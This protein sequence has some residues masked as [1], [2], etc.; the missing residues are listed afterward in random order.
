[1]KTKKILAFLLI[2]VFIVYLLPAGSANAMQIFVQIAVY[3]ALRTV[4]LEVEPGDYVYNIKSKVEDKTGIPTAF[5]QLYY[6]GVLLEDDHT[7]ADYNVQKESY[8]YLAVL[9]GGYAGN[10]DVDGDGAVTIADVTYLLGLL[11]GAHG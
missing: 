1:M 2:T 11:S 6:A 4:T 10:A 9:S 5:Q 8:L 3:G 7:L